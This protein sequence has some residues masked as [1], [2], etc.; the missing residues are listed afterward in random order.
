MRDMNRIEHYLTEAGQDLYQ[1]WV[2]RLRDRSARAR[3]TAR[4]NRMAAGAFGDSKPVGDGVWEL[5]VDWGPGYRVY[6][7]QAG[8]A[9]VLLLLG[10]DKRRQQA[11]IDKAIDCWSDY[12]R[13][14]P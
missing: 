4:V 3:I 11:D 1:E 2:E 14:T 6:Y 8:K 5:R 12:Q 13:R 10:G 7:A 9:L